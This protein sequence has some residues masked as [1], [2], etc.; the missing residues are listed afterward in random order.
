MIPTSINAKEDSLHKAC[1]GR[2]SVFSKED[3]QIHVLS[4]SNRPRLCENYLLKLIVE[5]AVLF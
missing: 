3:A 1:F 4:F 5:N 2:G